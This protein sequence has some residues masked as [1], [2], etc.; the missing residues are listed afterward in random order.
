MPISKNTTNAYHVPRSALLMHYKAEAY[1]S[2]PNKRTQMQ[3][4][5]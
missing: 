4:P 2:V 5:K 1:R 3:E